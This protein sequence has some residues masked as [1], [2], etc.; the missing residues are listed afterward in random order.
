MENIHTNTIK[1]NKSEFIH[2]IDIPNRHEEE[3]KKT[4]RKIRNI[5]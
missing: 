5:C 3:E 4:V 2:K 1:Q